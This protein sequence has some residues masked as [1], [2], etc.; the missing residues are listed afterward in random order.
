MAE[1]AGRRYKAFISYSWADAEW[2]AWVHH[3]LETYQTPKPLIGAETPLGPAPDR[4]HPIFKDREEEAAGGGIGAA[5]EA[6]LAASE[7]LIVVCSPASAKSQW[8]NREV[9]WFKKHKSKDRILALVVAGEPGASLSPTGGAECFPATLLYK[10]GAD[11][12]PTADLEDP[13]LAAD[14]R[15][16]GDGK[17]GAK[18]KLAAALLGVGLD[19]LVK[20][21]E[22]RRAVRR[23]WAMSGMA[24]GMAALGGLSLFAFNQ[25]DA[26]V[27]AR[28]D[29]VKARD[30]AEGLIELVLGDLKSDL[31]GYGTLKSVTQIGNR[32]IGYYEGQDVKA[33]TADQLGRRARVL[34]MLGEADNKRGDLDAALA[35]YKT[36]ETTTS[37]QLARDSDNAQRIFDHAQSV[38]WVGYIAWQR[39]DHAK[40]KEQFTEYHRLATRLVEIDPAN[41][42]W[43]AE[44]EYSY[45]NLGTLA[46]DDGDAAEAEGWFRKSLELALTRLKSASDDLDRVIAAGQAHAWLG[47]AQYRQAN[48]GLARKNRAAEL[49]LY[50]RA[51]QDTPNNGTLS[52]LVATAENSL[53][54]MSIAAGEVESSLHFARRSFRAANSSL[55]ADP[56]NAEKANRAIYSAAILGQAAYYSGKADEAYEALEKSLEIGRQFVINTQGAQFWL[57]S[58][59]AETRLTLARVEIASSNNEKALL[60]YEEV[61]SSLS[62]IISEQT[63]DVA[64]VRRYY[65]AISGKAKLTDVGD[66]SIWREIA[67]ALKAN[68]ENHGPDE[69]LLLAAALVQSRDLAA[70]ARIVGPLYESGYRHPDFLLLLAESPELESN[71][72]AGTDR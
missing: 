37:E 38:Y 35:R 57:L 4:L 70:A 31:E 26:A 61:I 3:A 55:E 50:M 42:D 62:P 65:S 33:L 15:K 20:R 72:F 2:G 29:A 67:T 19:A 39:G 66:S 58:S 43:Q 54:V 13:P 71:A 7:F 12:Q 47:D 36:A 30:D 28:N 18:L 64:I 6:A 21:D 11:L 8:V 45:S 9:A 40:A 25:R 24:A 56:Q 16:V 5:I 1:P 59:L 32:A 69:S 60:L 41:T 49:S 51:S 34:L 22:R 52:Q 46:M 44:L 23:R 68:A 27:I 17:R 10:V 14:A 48:I 53:A 63:S